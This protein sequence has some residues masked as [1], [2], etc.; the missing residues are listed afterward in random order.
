MVKVAE[1]GHNDRHRQGNSE[2]A[3]NGAHGAH[4][5][6]PHCGWIHVTVS[7]G[8]HGDD[9]PPESVWDAD[10]VSGVVVGFSKVYGTG[11]END[12]NEQEKD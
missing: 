2:H 7:H 1:V 12:T 9:S 11:E 10:K 5:F 4:H 3:S 6:T 8:G